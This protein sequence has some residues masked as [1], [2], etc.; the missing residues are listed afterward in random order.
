MPTP[1]HR[2][3]RILDLLEQAWD[4]SPQE[5]VE[6]LDRELADEPD[7]RAQVE[8]LLEADARAPGF[9][10]ADAVSFAAEAFAETVE[11]NGYED[12][13][14][15]PYRLTEQ[16][17]SGGMSLVF[18][19]T[20]ADGLYEQEVA[21]KLLPH[22]F[23]T[24]SRAARFR[25]ERQILATLDHPNIA[26]MLDGGVTDEGQPYLVME[27]IDG[28][29]LTTYCTEH[30][31]SLEERLELL[32]TVADALQHAHQ[33]L[34]VHRDLKPSNILVTGDGRV[35]L[36]D[37]GIAK[38]LSEEA[39][40]SA[41]LT[42][43]GQQPMTPAYAAPEQ[44][45]GEPI[46]TATDVYQLGILAY[47]LL[48]GTRPFNLEDKSPS[49]IQRAVV[50]ETPTRPSTALEQA[51]T[52]E[53]DSE[54]APRWATQLSGDLDTMVLKA[55]RK[56]PGRRYSSAASFS[57]DIERYLQ[58]RPV[59]ARP[60]TV[61]Y[62]TTKFVRRH[63]GELIVAFTVLLL[64]AGAVFALAHQ[65]SIAVQERDQAQLQAEKA[66]ASTG[67]LTDLFRASDPFQDDPEVTA[68]ELL[69]RG[70][71][72][73]EQ[74][75][76]RPVIQA[77]LLHAMG[78][79]NR[80]LGN[81]VTADSLLQDAIAL[82]EE[83]LGDTHP[84]TGAS[85]LARAQVM[86][87]EH[88]FHD[89]LPLL[90]K[91]REIWN[92][93]EITD[94]RRVDL[95]LT[96]GNILNQTGEAD[97]AESILREAISLHER[98]GPSPSHTSQDLQS[99]LAGSLQI[100]NRI[101]EADAIYRSLIEE[102]EDGLGSNHPA[103]AL[104]LNRYGLFLSHEKQEHNQ[105][106]HFFRRAHRIMRDEVGPA[107]PQTLTIKGNNLSAALYRQGKHEEVD[108]LRLALLKTVRAHYPAGHWREAS[109]LRVLGSLRADLN[110]LD[111]AAVVLQES[112][113]MYQDELGEDHAWT[114][115]AGADLGYVLARRGDLTEAHAVLAPADALLQATHPDSS[116][117]NIPR[118]RGI[119]HG[120]LGIYHLKRGNHQLA[121]SLLSSAYET[122]RHVQGD[123]SLRSE[124]VAAYLDTLRAVTND[125]DATA[126]R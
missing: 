84:S 108:S 83:H 72:R 59:E 80:Q 125:D 70:E 56:E 87:E 123:A 10:D 44:V 98:L 24:A 29:P 120:G 6:L 106:E 39:A 113:R 47:E 55:L 35:K 5:Q 96:L 31:C 1:E 121:D 115:G 116:T 19:A 89:A 45:M 82:R 49:E 81:Y 48:T 30:D 50:E 22:Y 101:D 109:A 111:T 122:L 28:V 16:L 17:G 103:L 62:R 99:G 41:P 76:K 54:P 12:V 77:E 97:S 100:Q 20:R 43:T 112:Y 46:S 65:R 40:L 117:A 4:L 104:T 32:R 124:A 21:I 74:L 95:G 7:L 86:E 119:A 2:W 53:A 51:A 34:I 58:D 107:H 71:E 11:T 8:R 13:H 67:F 23:K 69:E 14:V 36:L 102:Q 63:R 9:L 73:I 37:F 15:G 68:E 3:H 79:A 90:E 85:L 93:H 18:R 61:G 126:E 33:N 27:L 25:A 94:H 78:E 57:Q 64:I 88:F 38:L 75:D 60:A 105:A 92:E 42:R 66:E 118:G 110:R 91:V 26:Q 52:S 114:A